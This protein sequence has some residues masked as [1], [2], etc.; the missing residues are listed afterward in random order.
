MPPRPF[1]NTRRAWV[2]SGITARVWLEEARPCTR[3][4]G[5]REKTCPSPVGS[6]FSLACASLVT[7]PQVKPCSGLFTAHRQHEEKTN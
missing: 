7:T 3:L 4:I 2:F 1:G 5:R 6:D